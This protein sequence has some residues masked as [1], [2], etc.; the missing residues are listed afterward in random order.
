[1]VLGEGVFSWPALFI[2]TAIIVTIWILLE[3]QKFRHKI[4]T[5]FII[6]LLILMYVGFAVVSEGNDLD[7]K[8]V[9]GVVE[10]SKIYFAWFASV[11][12]NI[13]TV[14]S[15]AIHLDWSTPG[16]S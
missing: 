4:F 1:M 16:N 10:A 13:I 14:T 3:M 2:V 11:F 9:P 7:L 6:G 15:N 8:T 5:V 12:K